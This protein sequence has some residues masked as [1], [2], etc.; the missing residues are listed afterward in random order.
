MKATKQ[1]RAEHEAV[2]LVLRVFQVISGEIQNGQTLAEGHL[3]RLLEFLR[4]FVDKCHHA[5]EEELLFPLM[6]EK[7]QDAIAPVN[8][9][10]SEHRQGRNLV[11]ELSGEIEGYTKGDNTSGGK[12]VQGL[13]QYIELLAQHINKENQVL[14]PL[15]DSILTAAEQEQLFEAFEELEINRIGAGTHEEFHHMLEEFETLYLS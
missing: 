15:A 1:L 14:F 5:K 2:R 6:Q 13:E 4:V 10:L 3:D 7:D 12:I 8:A 11:K 9:M